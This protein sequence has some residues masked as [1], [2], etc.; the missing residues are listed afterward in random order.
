MTLNLTARFYKESSNVADETTANSTD[1]VLKLCSD[2]P[3]WLPLLLLL[4][5]CCLMEWVRAPPAT[6]RPHN[7]RFYKE[8][9]NVAEKTTDNS[10]GSGLKLCSNSLFWCESSNVAEETTANS[11]GSGLKL[12][13]DSLFW[14]GRLRLLLLE[15]CCPMEWVH[16]PP[17]AAR[18]QTARFH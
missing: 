18:P 6:S 17:A 13:S 14:C 2:S 8:S 5:G 10:P 1:S 11:T 9:S 15:G 7:A 12:C 3:F 16:A 4:E